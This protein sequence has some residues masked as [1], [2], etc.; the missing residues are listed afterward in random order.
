M[1]AYPTMTLLDLDARYGQSVGVCFDCQ[2]LVILSPHAAFVP[3]CA[4]C[5]GCCSRAED[6]DTV[7]AP[8]LVDLYQQAATVLG[9]TYTPP[10]G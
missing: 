3:R 7:G 4:P 9:A 1:P 10:G 6:T 2:S 8:T 5:G